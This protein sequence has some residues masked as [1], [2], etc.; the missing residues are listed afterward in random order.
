MSFSPAVTKSPAGGFAGFIRAA[1]SGRARLSTVATTFFTKS[2]GMNRASKR[3]VPMSVAT[4][5]EAARFGSMSSTGSIGFWI[6][7]FAATGGG[8]A[9]G[10]PGSADWRFCQYQTPAPIASSMTPPRI[11]R[12]SFS[13]DSADSSRLGA[14][15]GLTVVEPCPS[16]IISRDPA[17]FET[18]PLTPSI[19]SGF[20]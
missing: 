3:G 7:G 9:G 11:Q 15:M 20:H 5:S 13:S 16:G 18:V 14:Y 1:T 19:Q 10:A 8:T 4:C 17:W 12:P 2:S 6:A